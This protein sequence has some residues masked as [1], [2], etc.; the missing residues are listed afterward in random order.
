MNDKTRIAVVEDNTAFRKRLVDVLNSRANWS[1]VAECPDAASAFLKIPGAKPDLILLDIRL[2]GMTGLDAIPR[3]RKETGKTPIVM[4]TVEDRA[5]QIV[6]ALEAGAS[7]YI[8]KGESS[9]ELLESVG[10]FLAGR[11]SMSPAIARRLVG[12]FNQR[13]EQ[14]PSEDYGLTDRQWEILK[15]AS[16]GK[17]QGEIALALSISIYTV[18][19]HFHNIYEKLN[20]NSLREALIKLKKGRGLLED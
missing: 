2:P 19:N 8:L 1:V 12:W 15:M 11:A 18:K 14:T 3:L 4:L 5:D 13:Q 16:K 9:N 7:G 20:V 10:D 6:Q 17:Q